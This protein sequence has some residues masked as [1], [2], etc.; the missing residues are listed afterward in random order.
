M[1]QRR[2]PFLCAGL[3]VSLLLALVPGARAEVVSTSEALALGEGAATRA[4]V[5]AYLARQEVAAELASLGVDPEVA[6]L[7]AAA[8]TPLE[9]E[10]M[11]GRIAEAPAGGAVIEVLGITFLVLLILELVGVIDIFK[12]P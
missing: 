9:L 3:T 5:D 8:L 6:R 4:V 11:A 7:R 2:K 12:K 1:D 10:A